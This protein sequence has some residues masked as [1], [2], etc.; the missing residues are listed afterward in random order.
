MWC[1]EHPKCSCT[2]S[3]GT[4][5]VTLTP[6]RASPNADNDHDTIPTRVHYAT[7]TNPTHTHIQTPTTSAVSLSLSLS[8]THTL[9]WFT[10]PL[11]AL[12]T[13]VPVVLARRRRWRL[14]QQPAAV[15]D[16]LQRVH[17]GVWRD[18]D[19]HQVLCLCAAVHADDVV[20]R[21]DELRAAEQHI[22]ATT[23]QATLATAT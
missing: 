19:D 10:A 17:N 5:T 8:R 13:A 7:D 3:A 18:D 2:D 21:R 11:T 20:R 15:G 23:V 16:A 1:R 6:A 9:R 4:R 14:R 22:A 12:H